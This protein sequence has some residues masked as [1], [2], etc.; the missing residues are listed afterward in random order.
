MMTMKKKIPRIEKEKCI[1][2]HKDKKLD[3]ITK[4][5]VFNILVAFCRLLILFVFLIKIILPL[6]LSLVM[7]FGEILFLP[8]EVFTNKF[9]FL[10]TVLAISQYILIKRLWWIMNYLISIYEK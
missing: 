6:A 8:E 1:P 3:V 9:M 7:F 5:R 2:N 4:K 10:I